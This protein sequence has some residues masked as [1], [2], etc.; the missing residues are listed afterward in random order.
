MNFIKKLYQRS[1]V[2]EFFLNFKILAS[3][4][5]ISQI[6]LLI[7]SPLITRIYSPEQF[8]VFAI[9]AAILS[10]IV[11]ISSF[12]YNNAIVVADSK[13]NSDDLFVLSILITA[14]FSIVLFFI[15][16]F[17]EEFF[18]EVLNAKNLYFWWYLIPLGIL[19]QSVN[20]VSR[21][22]LNYKK[23]YKLISKL[24]IIRSICYVTIVISA[25]YLG[26]NNSGLFLAEIFSALIIIIAFFLYFKKI[27]YTV[28]INFNGKLFVIL[29][30]YKDFPVY[31]LLAGF[32][33]KFTVMMPIFFLSKYFSEFITGQYSL[34][35]KVIVFPLT[36][37][38]S[39][40][41][42]IHLKK[43]SDIIFKN[44]DIKK[45]LKNL[46]F[47]LISI[48]IV[49]TCIFLFFGPKLFIFIFG[50]DWRIAGEFVQILIPALAI[51]FVVSTLSPILNAVRQLHL[52]TAWN[53][54]S[55][56]IT[57]VY[58]YLFSNTLEIRDLLIY[59]VLL[60]ILL[61]IFYF[62]LIFFSIKDYNFKKFKN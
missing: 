36:F 21:S 4:T 49:P 15:L 50:K 2:S 16:F 29:K 48:I 51:K 12:K 14:S 1:K 7:A 25:G 53:V 45:Y 6:I 18:K 8:G 19:F 27:G 32:L 31:S 34:S 11:P 28:P 59:Y 55:F 22:Y 13:K 20:E 10:I 52:Y 40:I 61:Y 38:S 41:A 54:I 5:I 30:K 43:S 3:G 42:A 58:F 47:I 35:L 33:N 60:N 9:F 23:N 24:S 46:S 39:S 17:F 62:Y 44:G 26:Y 56:L 37:I 57:F